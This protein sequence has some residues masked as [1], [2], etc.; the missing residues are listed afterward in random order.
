MGYKPLDADERSEGIDWRV[1]P[2]FRQY[3]MRPCSVGM[4]SYNELVLLDL[5]EVAVMNDDIQARA[6]NERLAREHSESNFGS[7]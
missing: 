6:D 2:D 3:V 1:L 5:S 4:I 7:K